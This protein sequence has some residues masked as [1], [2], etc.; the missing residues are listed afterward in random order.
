MFTLFMFSIGFKQCVMNTCMYTRGKG[1][2]PIIVGIHV[3]DQVIVGPD[4]MV[5]KAFKQ[6]LSGKF[7]MK[8]V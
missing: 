6:E 4:P 1:H 2:S 5:I 8:G 7:K 3:D